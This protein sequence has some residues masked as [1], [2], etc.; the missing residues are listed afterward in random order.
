M[1]SN[2]FASLNDLGVIWSTHGGNCPLPKRLLVASDLLL[3][4]GPCP[5]RDF[6]QAFHKGS[7]ALVLAYG[8]P[9][10]A[11]GLRVVEEEDVAP[12]SGWGLF[13]S[14]HAGH[15]NAL[16]HDAFYNNESAIY[17]PFRNVTEIA[18][19][20]DISG[21]FGDYSP[22]VFL[23]YVVS[24]R[25]ASL[26]GLVAA[27]AQQATGLQVC[28]LDR[29][30]LFSCLSELRKKLPEALTLVDGSGFSAE[31]AKKGRAKALLYSTNWI[32]RELVDASE[33]RHSESD[34]PSLFDLRRRFSL[35][36]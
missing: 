28:S 26:V 17:V 27:L 3:S 29:S 33:L 25:T 14:Q 35:S 1:Q 16:S 9:L 21:L 19:F 6:D 4:I 36:S 8:D 23:R 13:R 10:Y 18:P 34:V 7:G 5:D 32:S 22:G 15:F 30:L 20:D 11:G 2:D 31:P 24:P 12:D